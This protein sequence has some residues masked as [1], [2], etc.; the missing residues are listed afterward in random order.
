MDRNIWDIAITLPIVLCVS[1]WYKRTTNELCMA[2]V[3]DSNMTE[4]MKVCMNIDI[5]YLFIVYILTDY[6]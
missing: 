6:K 2:E 3:W 4:T 1:V 5:Q